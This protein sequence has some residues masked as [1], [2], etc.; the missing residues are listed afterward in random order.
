MIKNPLNHAGEVRDVGLILGWGRSPG[1]GDGQPIPVS[2]LAN[3]MSR[4]AWWARV[5]G[6][7]KTWTQPKRIS[8]NGLH[9]K[10]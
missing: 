4:G 3:S 7:T 5:H 2:C 1:T 9:R 6:I 10:K 8:T